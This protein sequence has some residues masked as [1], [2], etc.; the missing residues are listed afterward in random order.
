MSF[1]P[2][3]SPIGV[4]EVS[5]PS[6]KKPMPTITITAPIIKHMSIDAGTGIN[7]ASSPR[8]MSVTGKTDE[9]DSFIFS[10][11]TVLL[12]MFIVKFLSGGLL[13]Y[14]TTSFLQMQSFGAKLFLLTLTCNIKYD[15]INYVVQFN[16]NHRCSEA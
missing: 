2:I 12:N 3:Y 10:D 8:T 15:I 4:I 16:E 6:V 1:E 7:V 11:M 14:D 9:S 5:A 13:Y